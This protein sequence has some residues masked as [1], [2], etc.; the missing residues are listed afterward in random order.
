VFSTRSAVEEAARTYARQ[1]LMS[2]ESPT[3]AKAA[4]AAKPKAPRKSKPAE[5]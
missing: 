1:L 5:A 3:L 4:A 2:T